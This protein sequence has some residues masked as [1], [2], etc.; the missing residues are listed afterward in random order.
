MVFPKFRPQSRKDLGNIYIYKNI[1]TL[2]M[3]LLTS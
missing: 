1:D 2:K 3:N